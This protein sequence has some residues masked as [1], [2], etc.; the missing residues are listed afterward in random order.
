MENEEKRLF[1]GLEVLAPW[2][3]NLPPGRF[4]D[5]KHRHLTVAFLGKT[6]FPLLQ[7]ALETVPQPPFHVGLAGRFTECIFLPKRYPNVAA[8][9]V[10]WLDDNQPLTAYQKTFVDWLL[11]AGFPPSQ[12][13]REWL[14]HVTLCRKPFHPAQW[15]KSFK[16][17]PMISSNLHLYESVGGLRYEPVWTLPLLPPFEE[18]EHTA[19]IAFMVHGH[20]LQDILLHA[21]TALAFKFPAFLDFFSAPETLDSIDD[22]IISLNQLITDAD[23][24]IG[25]PMKA[26]SFHG[27]VVVIKNN[28]LQW[29]MIIDV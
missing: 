15:A 9:N 19:D 12:P 18:L 7:K 24:E 5:E 22:V 2:P 11:K 3:P 28:V 26:V 4:L 1:F 25:C 8:W 20:T 10:A 13:N 29:E 6:N 23:R 17:L 21:Q 16:P 27:E 14:P